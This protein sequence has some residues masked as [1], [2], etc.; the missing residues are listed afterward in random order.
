MEFRV[1]DIVTRDGTDLQKILEINDAG[2]LILVVCVRAPSA[3]LNDDGTR[4]EPWCQVG[5]EE[6]NLSRRYSFPDELTIEGQ[7]S[8]PSITLRD[9]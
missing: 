3:W 9:S 8:R 1:G 4:D 2:D 5:E 7:A 6:W